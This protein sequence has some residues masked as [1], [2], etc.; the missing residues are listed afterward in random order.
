MIS[1]KYSIIMIS[2]FLSCLTSIYAQDGDKILTVGHN[3]AH[4]PVTINMTQVQDHRIWQ[5][6]DLRK[7]LGLKPYHAHD[8]LHRTAQK[9]SDRARA[10]W[11]ISHRRTG[12]QAYYSYPLIKKRF[13]QEWVQFSGK[14]TLFVEN[15]GYGY[16]K[17]KKDDGT[18]DL[19]QAMQST[20]RFFIAEKYKKYQA[21]YRSMINP[22]YQFAGVWA[23]ID[24]KHKTYYLT[25]HYSQAIK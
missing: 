14:G 25:I 17:C 3:T 21:H 12:S 15:V 2:C 13:A 16:I 8:Q 20:W 10:S 18:Q 22:N 9:R 11:S 7:D 24:L 6:N 19:I 23:A 1:T 4:H 5:V